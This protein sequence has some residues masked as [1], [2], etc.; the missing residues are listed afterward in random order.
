MTRL[1]TIAALCFVAQLGVSFVIGAGNVATLL[2]PYVL[3]SL[4]ALNAMLGGAL[5]ILPSVKSSATI[6]RQTGDIEPALPPR[7]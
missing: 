4:G 1:Q 5:L 3:L 7:G 6:I 2:S